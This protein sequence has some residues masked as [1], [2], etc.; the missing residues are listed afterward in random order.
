MN[1]SQDMGAPAEIIL[2][3]T[4][5]LIE[6]ESNFAKKVRFLNIKQSSY[7]PNT[8]QHNNFEGETL[9]ERSYGYCTATNNCPNQVWEYSLVY[10]A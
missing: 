2:D 1:F 9:L 4:P 10:E 8:Q 3:G 6:R 7:K 5:I